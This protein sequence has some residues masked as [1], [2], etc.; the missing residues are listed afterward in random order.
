M[1]GKKLLLT[2]ECKNSIRNIALPIPLAAIIFILK[3]CYLGHIS[4][5]ADLQDFIFNFG[6]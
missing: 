5:A 6:L 1:Y 4:F 3:V 2:S